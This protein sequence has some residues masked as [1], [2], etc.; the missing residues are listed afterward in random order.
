MFT[1]E[2]STAYDAALSDS[3]NK[4]I[5]VAYRSALLQRL[6]H[7]VDPYRLRERLPRAHAIHLRAVRLVELQDERVLEAQMRILAHL[8]V[9]SPP[10]PV[11]E[12]VEL[13]RR[14][15]TGAVVEVWVSSEEIVE[16]SVGRE[17]ALT[18]TSTHSLLVRDLRLGSAQILLARSTTTYGPFG[19]RH[20]SS[21]FE[22]RSYYVG[23]FAH[24]P[25]GAGAG[26][27][28][29]EAGITA[30]SRRGRG[31]R[32]LLRYA[33]CLRPVLYG[34]GTLGNGHGG[35]LLPS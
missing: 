6:R 5:S 12:A 16:G 8:A 3:M 28:E 27:G 2:I 15:R 35:V 24:V 20:H 1:W 25:V 26:L 7:G 29:L 31:V 11:A 32:E 9:L 30:H 10:K 22:A 33:D 13:L 4:Q 21:N 18:A 23:E 17:G 19:R 14:R 34:Q